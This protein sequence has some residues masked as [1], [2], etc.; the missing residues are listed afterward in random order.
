LVGLQECTAKRIKT[1]VKVAKRNTSGFSAAI[2][3]SGPKAE[4]GFPQRVWGIDEIELVQ[5]RV[6]CFQF[7]AEV[8]TALADVLT[9]GPG[10]R[11]VI[12]SLFTEPIPKMISF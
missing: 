2:S 12:G 7:Q 5:S 6:N 10:A 11:A 3:R 9:R 1:K 8:I 4:G